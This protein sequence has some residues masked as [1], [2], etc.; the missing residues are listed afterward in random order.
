[1][2]F[3]NTLDTVEVDC[4]VN[5][6][7]NK[8]D[9]NEITDW[10]NTQKEMDLVAGNATAVDLQ[11][12]E[13][14]VGEESKD[15]LTVVTKDV[16]NLEIDTYDAND[17]RYHDE[18][19]VQINATAQINS[20]QLSRLS[21]I[22]FDSIRGIFNCKDH[23]SRNIVKT[24]I[25][26]YHSFRDTVDGG[27]MHLVAVTLD[28]NT[29]NLWENARSYVHYHLGRQSWKLDDGTTL[30]LIKIHQKT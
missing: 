27:F 13:V 24:H 21:S 6:S 7:I 4:V 10:R 5:E 14:Q 8:V 20:I 22:E 23:L 15:K 12:N 28:V 29:K 2:E 26:K 9:G 17:S 25:G 3:L 1:M 30:K 19:T 11:T 16:P 18:G